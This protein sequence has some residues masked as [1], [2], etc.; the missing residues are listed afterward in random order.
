[1]K[2]VR[3]ATGA[4]L[5]ALTALVVLASSRANSQDTGA[6]VKPVRVEKL[7][8][9]PGQTLT[10]SFFEPP[11]SRHLVSE[12]ASATE[13]AN[14]LVIFVAEDGAQLTTFDK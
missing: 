7:A 10:V 13:P 6:A 1:M 14:M 5:V 12:N 11:Q 4:V 9:A 3:V 2:K 8:N